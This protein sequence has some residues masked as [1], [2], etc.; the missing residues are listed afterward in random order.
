MPNITFVTDPSDEYILPVLTKVLDIIHTGKYRILKERL[1]QSI[2]KYDIH[3]DQVI[4]QSLIDQ[5]SYCPVEFKLGQRPTIDEIDHI[6]RV[7]S[8]LLLTQVDWIEVIEDTSTERR[9]I[10]RPQYRNKPI[11][12]PKSVVDDIAYLINK[13]ELPPPKYQ[14]WSP[15]YLDGN[16]RNLNNHIQPYHIHY[17]FIKAWILTTRDVDQVDNIK[18][19]PNLLVEVP[20][21]DSNN[22]KTIIDMVDSMV[23]N[24]MKWTVIPIKDQRD[25]YR[26]RSRYP[27]LIVVDDKLISEDTLSDIDNLPEPIVPE[28]LS[29]DPKEINGYYYL[30]SGS[31]PLSTKKY[32]EIQITTSRR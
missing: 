16:F 4:D 20:P 2:V 22:I 12:R 30:L 11:Y 26:Y 23:Q 18:V 24:A 28:E 1:D 10:V 25:I 19:Y 31:K 15:Y 5:I 21:T 8:R 9:F 32:P 17:A 13:P 27:S 29:K 3:T 6:K 14:E 7:T